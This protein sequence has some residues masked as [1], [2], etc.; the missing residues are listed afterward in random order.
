MDSSSESDDAEVRSCSLNLES[1]SEENESLESSVK[2]II[3]KLLDFVT[4]NITARG[5]KRK[6]K[7][8]KMSLMER[9]RLKQM[10]VVNKHA[11]KTACKE[12]CKK[13]CILNIP[14]ERRLK[15]NE[16]YWK[17]STKEQKTYMFNKMKK[18]KCSKK[19]Y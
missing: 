15:I 1:I 3:E 10:A 17:M 11:V 16:E 5:T 19:T 7:K 18:K 14:A 4:D 2:F 9:N 6:R 8:Y 13:K 12:S